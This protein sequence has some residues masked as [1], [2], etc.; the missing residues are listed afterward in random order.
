MRCNDL[1]GVG[2]PVLHLVGCDGATSGVS[3][4]FWVV[5]GKPL[6]SRQ[7]VGRGKMWIPH[8][9]GDILMAQKFLDGAQVNPG[10]HKTAGEGVPEAMPREIS[11]LGR[12]ER[13]LE[14]VTR[15]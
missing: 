8:G 13:R 14:P 7:G 3:R 9:H 6:Y 11:N 15:V 5:Q 10:H 1:L 4:T 12:T 2:E